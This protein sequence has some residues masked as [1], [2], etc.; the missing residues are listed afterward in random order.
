MAG[1][2]LAAIQLLPTWELKQR[3]TRVITGGDYDPAYGQMPP[4]YVTQA[5]APWIWYSPLAIGEENIV[6]DIAE[7]VAPWHWFGPVY[8]SRQSGQAFDLDVALHRCRFAAV[9]TGTNKVEAHFYCGLVPIS[10]ALCSIVIWLRTRRTV[11][12]TIKTE[13]VFQRS[14]GFWL[15]AG[16]FALV[17][18]TGALL[19]IGRHLPGFSFFRGPGRYGIVTTLVIA[20]LAGQL[21][22]QM[23]L[24]IRNRSVR[25]IVLTLIFAS[26]CGD[27]WLVSRMVRYTVMVSPPRIS[28][29]ESS[30]VRR[31]LLEEPGLPRLLSPGPN[32]GNL[33]GASCVPWYLGIAPAE[34]VDPQFAMPPIPKPPTNK[35]PTPSTPELLEWLSRSGV[36]HVLNFEPLEEDSWHVE[37][38]WKG[39]DPFLN[40]VWAREEPI[41]LYRFLSK[42]SSNESI[43]FPG[44]AYL[45]DLSAG[46][47][48]ID[49]MSERPGS[50]QVIVESESDSSKTLVLTE[51]AFPGWTIRSG[52]S[53]LESKKVGMFR[54]VDL[55]EGRGEVTWTY[56][57]YS[58]YL[59][60]A[61]SLATFL[62]LAVV[63]HFRF[64]HPH[65]VDRMLL[66]FVRSATFCETNPTSTK[67]K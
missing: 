45:T 62:L 27:L 30:E 20:L 17:Y 44:R 31:L 38:I 7:F 48:P 47:S 66:P 12:G 58:F 50:R 21:L 55:P 51:L 19:P 28:F 32:V 63:A 57:P 24:H 54:A 6:R 46:V 60:A 36:T 3:S 14:I 1:A 22:G 5:I 67:Q 42:D 2:G 34:Y 40:R 64:W 11:P 35:A 4:I 33:L 43:R 65:L 59:G 26:T 29:R 16:L 53:P 15:I 49:P 10:M 13:S 18:A 37:L 9:S 41:F 52:D 25:V 56:Q 61:I 8:D 23:M 39:I